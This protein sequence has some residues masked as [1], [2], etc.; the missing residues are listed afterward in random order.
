MARVIIRTLLLA[1]LIVIAGGLLWLRSSLPPHDGRLALDGLAAEAS[2]ARDAHGI[3]TIRAAN[4]HDAAFALGFVHAGDRL[5]QMDLMRRAG[6]GRLSEWF[7]ARSLRTD[8]FMRTIGL[9]RAAE[10]ELP[11]LSPPL[12]AVLE[13]YA[14]G[15]NAY[16]AGRRGALPAEYYLLNV[17]PEPWQPVDTLVWGKLMSLQLA[18]N[19]R[20]ELLHAR[21]AQR[22]SPEELQILYPPYPK[23]APV[24]LSEAG[25]LLESVDLAGIAQNLPG[26]VGPGFASNNWVVDGAHS[27]SGKPLLANDPH[28]GL[29][30][31]SVW[32]LARIETP[33]L[34]L[35]GV[36]APGGPAVI[37]G[38]NQRIA[39]GFTNTASDVEDLFIE[40][41]D[42]ADPTRY[43]APGGSEPFLSR[44]E[45]IAVR[46]GAP[47][48]L[49]VRETRHGPVISD[50]GGGE[51]ETAAAGTVLAL[52]ATFLADDD[53]TPEALRGIDRA[54]D[55]DAFRAALKDFVAPEQNVV[56][57]DIDGNIGFLAPARVPIRAKGDGWL[58][59][60]G[61]SGEYDWTGTVPFDRLPSA[62][63]PA[64]GRLLSANNKIVGDDYPYYLGRGWDLPNR[65]E[66][67]A[68]LLDAT[69]LQSPAASAA[70]QADTLSLMAK[71]LLP[72]MLAAAPA[73][74]AAA[75]AL[76][77]LRAWDGRMERDR[78]AP[79]LFTAWLR[80]FNRTLFADRLGA[81]FD[82]YWGLHP[83]VVRLVLTEH[84]EWCD[85]RSTPKVESCADQL[86][87]SLERALDQLRRRF[88][89]D[90]ERWRWGTPHRAQFANPFWSSIPV[91]GT[92]F[93][94]TIPANGGYDTLNRGDT[95]HSGGADPYADL[96]GPSLRMIVDFADL[97]GARFMIAPGQ[98]GNVLSPHYR[99]LMKEWRDQAYVRLDGEPVGGT[100]VLAPR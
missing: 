48:A 13:A 4:E 69:P 9:Y 25:R 80:E 40:R 95:A 19:F 21:L 74:K 52:Q 66:R 92:L 63:N 97:D 84:A 78:A 88:G 35:A 18:G 8:R 67:I 20:R 100:L 62:F 2:I 42:P 45:T 85:D 93:A 98:S 14:A 7:G 51:A 33:G 41:V 31:P 10:R 16:L 90:M 86:A 15:V 23:D 28:L 50:L 70:M 12:R 75:E 39:W 5:F 53:R 54:L 79:L 87:A 60:P 64:R 81:A 17:A 36:T 3:P 6:A 24:T 30:A 73:S 43:L 57:A 96:L 37:I 27:V 46:D 47:V 68:Q 72:L 58:P 26:F 38:H 83:D 71:D 94:T 77:R 49:T 61:W 11:L 32:Y 22:L 82:D 59:V 91:L 76:D 99:D 65:A 29:S 1:P 34:S 89:A 55:W 56:Y 44:N